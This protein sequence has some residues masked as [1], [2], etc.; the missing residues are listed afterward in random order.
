[1]DKGGGEGVGAEGK[2]RGAQ[3]IQVRRVLLHAG[4]QLRDVL[5]QAGLH[6]QGLGLQAQHTLLALLR[7]LVL[8]LPLP[9]L[10]ALQLALV[11]RLG[12]ELQRPPLRVLGL[13]RLRHLLQ[14]GLQGLPLL[15]EGGLIGLRKVPERGLATPPAFRQGR[16]EEAG[17]GV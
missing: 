2:G 17:R 12:A 16:T 5:L 1:M 8:L 13:R 11:V 9:G 4:L 14:F 6:L 10:Q 15:L 3:T 7:Q